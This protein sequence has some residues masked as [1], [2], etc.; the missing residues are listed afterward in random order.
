MKRV[1]RF[2]YL[3]VGVIA[4]LY[5]LLL[6]SKQH[7][8]LFFSGDSSDW[9]ASSIWWMVPQPYGSPLFITLGHLINSIPIFSLV[10]R[11]TIFM[12][13][14][15]ASITVATTYLI[16]KKLTNVKIAVVCSLVLLG[17]AIYLTQATILDEFAIS[18]MFVSLAF[19][20]YLNDKKK[21]IVLMLALGSAIQI[22]VVAISGI[23]FVLHLNE[24]KKWWKTYWIYAV[25]GILPYG[26]TLLLMYLPTPRLLSGHLSIEAINNYLGATGTIASLSMVD[27]PE[28]IL[29]FCSIFLA[30]LGLALVPVFMSFKGLTKYGKPM[31]VAVVTVLFILWLYITDKDPGTWHFLPIAY[32]LIMIFVALGLYK[33]GQVHQKVVAYGAV[34]LIIINGV[35]L[36]ANILANQYP[37]A[38]D[39]E[40]ELWDLPDGSYVVCSSG[41]NY[42]LDN[43]Y[44]MASGKDIRPIFID[45]EIPDIEMFSYDN[46]FEYKAFLANYLVENY[47]LKMKQAQSQVEDMIKYRAEVGLSPRYQDYLKWMNERYGLQGTN[48]IAQVEWL[49]SQGE[50]VYLTNPV[51]TPYWENIFQTGYLKYGLLSEITG[52]NID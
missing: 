10:V 51:V 49:L 3:I 12:D 2:D 4:F 30:S 8:F 23:W 52:V 38:S 18:S 24:I 13:V 40:K 46:Q 14:I 42:G 44:V 15:P 34:A 36:N 11:M 22:I 27:S 29:Q 35:F 16:C 25:V 7:T 5:Y 31:L 20:F 47:D 6:F 43:Y 50:Q 28:R 21:L 37:L 33:M 1:A 32:P 48:T 19:Y 45:G 39:Y 26:L 17:S 9:L 41:G